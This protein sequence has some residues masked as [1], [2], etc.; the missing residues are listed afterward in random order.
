MRKTNGKMKGSHPKKEKKR[1]NAGAVYIVDS[2]CGRK[3]ALVDNFTTTAGPAETIVKA[4]RGLFGSVS[5]IMSI[6]SAARLL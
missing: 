6:M 5:S 3:R 1:Q 2:K 4:M